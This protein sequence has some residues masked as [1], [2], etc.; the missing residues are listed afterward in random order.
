[1]GA[2]G[3]VGGHVDFWIS[4]SNR[5][6]GTIRQDCAKENRKMKKVELVG[7]LN[8]T[9]DSFSDGGKYTSTDS[10]LKHA[11]RL[12][13]D[14]ADIIDV[15]AESTRPGAEQ[16][17]DDEEWMRLAEIWP[18]LV[19]KYNGKL[20]LDTYHPATVRKASEYGDFIVN[21]VTAFADPEMIDTVSELNLRC[22]ISHLPFAAKGNIQ[23][24]HTGKLVETVA[25]VRDELLEK[26]ELLI[27]AGIRKDQIILDPGIGFGKT[28]ETNWELLKFAEHVPDSDV[29]IGYSRKRFLGENRMDNE[30]NL[31]AGKIAIESGAKY[32]RV[33][34]AA[35][36]RE[37]LERP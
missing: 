18:K 8:I 6:D 30:P 32:L 7:I 12:Y 15:G 22:I 25:Q 3:V 21:D 34:D 5:Q 26:R 27:R 33:H 11:E 2:I 31:A 4:K 16:L 28:P 20:S 9:P 35:A 23:A 13:T 24:A 29:M 1:M 36:H 10:A 17:S 14:G 19:Q 37:L